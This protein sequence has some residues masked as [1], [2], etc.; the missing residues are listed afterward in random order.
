MYHMMER[1]LKIK[2]QLGLNSVVCVYD[3]A[4]YEK[5]FQIKCK[6]PQKFESLFLM[7]GTFHV[8]LTFLAV[9]AA[10]FKDAG[11]KDIVIQSSTVAEGSAD[12]MFSGS[13]AY[14]R[15]IQVY[16]ILYEVFYK[17]LLEGFEN[18]NA[19][20]RDALI[21]MIDSQ[22]VT[23]F[24]DYSNL[25][26]SKEMQ[27]YS[28]ELLDYKDKIQQKSSLARFC[29]SFLDMVEILLN[30]VYSTRARNW[31]LYVETIRSTQPWF[32]AYDRVNYSRY[33]TAH[34]MDLLSL[35]E[36]YPEVYLEF[37]KGNFS[38]QL[39]HSSTFGRMEADK[40]IETTINKDTK[41][42]GGTT[43]I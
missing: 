42:P 24:P 32:F 33:L 40:T 36:K 29:I 43:G 20:E 25:M 34:F 41:T 28:T 11:L 23:N 8:I 2:N 39:S 37:V 13:R 10:R 7:M 21:T 15:A 16:K 30:L 38:V 27:T 35:E 6:E 14:K 9:I 22:T 19:E 4:I 1:S 31:Y 26:T 3:Q 5:A 12:T 18:E 17:I